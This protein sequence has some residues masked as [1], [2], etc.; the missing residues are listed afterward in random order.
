[1]CWLRVLPV[2]PIKACCC[3]CSTVEKLV[4]GRTEFTFLCDLSSEL[5]KPR[6]FL[7]VIEFLLYAFFT[8]FLV[9]FS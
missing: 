3:L 5:P 1:M 8:Y 9:I 2:I 4:G 6:R 7:V